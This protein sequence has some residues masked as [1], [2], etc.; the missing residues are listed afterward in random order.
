MNKGK[1]RMMR[2]ATGVLLCSFTTA[3]PAQP[4][5]PIQSSR[6]T[7]GSDSSSAPADPS[8]AIVVEAT[9]A[10]IET[11]SSVQKVAENGRRLSSGQL[12]SGDTV[13]ISIRCKNKGS[14]LRH[15]VITQPIPDAVLYTDDQVVAKIPPDTT[16]LYSID[17][18]RSFST[19]DRLTVRQPQ[20]RPATP[21][22]VTH[23]RW[24]HDAPLRSD[25]NII[26]AFQAVVR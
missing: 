22:D 4:Y 19:L 14:L 2:F 9:S 24:V 6:Q 17:R 8:K 15:I 23:I 1:R 5:S 21:A 26:F 13:L 10:D 11:T 20:A 18:G 3:V 7:T 16:V 25:R 12:A